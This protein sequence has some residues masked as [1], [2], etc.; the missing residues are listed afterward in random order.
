MKI[1]RRRR[2]ALSSVYPGPPKELFPLDLSG[3]AR[4]SA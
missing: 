3:G 2:A 1:V 4:V